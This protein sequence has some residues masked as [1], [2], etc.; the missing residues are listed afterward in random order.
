MYLDRL[1]LNTR[2]IRYTITLHVVFIYQ[3]TSKNGRKYTQIQ[4]LLNF[5]SAT[6]I[7]GAAFG[8]GVAISGNKKVLVVG[9]DGVRNSG[10]VAVGAV[11]IYRKTHLGYTLSQGIQPADLTVAS[12]F[13]YGVRRHIQAYLYCPLG[14]KFSNDPYLPA[15]TRTPSPG[16]ARSWPSLLTAKIWTVR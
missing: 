16:T 1:A 2:L 9:A 3:S 11:Y 8:R 4:K 7:F 14:D 15:H 5:D 6:G 12:Y 10:G 13:G